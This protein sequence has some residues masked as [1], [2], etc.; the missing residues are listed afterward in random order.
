MNQDAGH[1]LTIDQVINFRGELESIRATIAEREKHLNERFTQQELAAEF[2][3]AALK[4]ALDEAKLTA[5]RAGAAAKTNVEERLSEAK[6]AAD[7]RFLVLQTRTE[8]LESGGAP[9]ASRLDDGIRKLNEDVATLNNNAVR[10]EVVEAL[11]TRQEEDANTQ[12]RQIKYIAIASA[13]SLFSTL[14][15]MAIALLK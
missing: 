11:R 13:I 4:D 2:K 10:A 9:F 7:E 1:T 6:T 3:R 14:L 8:K 5:D 15:V 12:K